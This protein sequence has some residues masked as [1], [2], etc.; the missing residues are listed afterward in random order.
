MIVKVL[1]V[2]NPWADWI[3]N[4]WRSDFKTTENRTWETAYRGQLYIHV[5]KTL[6]KRPLQ[7]VKPRAD[8]FAR[9]ERQRGCIIGSV[10]LYAID[11]EVKTPWDEP[12]LYHWRVR[13]PCTFKKPIPTRGALGL[14]DFDMGGEKT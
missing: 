3:I 10:E 1:T 8:D 4:S 6:D 9:W 2:K 5:S 7:G 11:K 12:G 14:W 13:N